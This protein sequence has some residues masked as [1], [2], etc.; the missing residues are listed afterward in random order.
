M[1][2]IRISEHGRPRDRIDATPSLAAAGCAARVAVA[3]VDDR[4][5]ALIFPASR[6]VVLDRLRK[7]LR[8]DHVRLAVCDEVA[9]F[10]GVPPTGADRP[11]PAPPGVPLLMDASLLSARA[12]DFRPDREGESI[13]LPLE[14]WLAAA[15]PAL[16][17]FSEPGGGQDE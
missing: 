16:G 11:A 1:P 12:L 10:V 5:V 15:N 13:R 6:R 3:V 17:F 2:A 8:A 7:L 9:R 4:P 14:D